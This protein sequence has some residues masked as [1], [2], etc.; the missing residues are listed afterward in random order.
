LIVNFDE[1]HFGEL[2]E[3]RHERL[4]D[5]VQGAVRL[6]T[7]SE[8][9]VRDTVGIFDF[10]VT[11]ETVQYEPE[12]LVAFHIA[13][14]FEIFIKYRADQIP[15][16][17]HEARHSDLIGKLPADQTVVVCEVDVNFHK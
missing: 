1:L 3:I 12:A 14:T 9:N 6:T 11:V 8:I 7:T 2:F 10:A 16:G 5:G 4:G 15:G 13:G 17:W